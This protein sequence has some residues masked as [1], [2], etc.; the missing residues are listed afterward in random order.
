MIR[1]LITSNGN[2]ISDNLFVLRMLNILTEIKGSKVESVWNNLMVKY[3]NDIDDN[4]LDTK[5][6]F[7][8]IKKVFDRAYAKSP[9]VNFVEGYVTSADKYKNSVP[10][11]NASRLSAGETYI[12][13]DI[14]MRSV[15]FEYVIVYFIWSKEGGIKS[16]I[17]TYGSCFKY[18]LYL[19]DNCC[20][21][22]NLDSVEGWQGILLF[23]ES[24]MDKNNFKVASDLFWGMMA[25]AICHE[26]SH[27]YLGHTSRKA[28]NSNSY[29]E[30]YVADSAGYDIFLRMLS[31]EFSDIDS[32]FSEI[33]DDYIYVAPMLLFL[34]YD[35]VYYMSYWLFDEKA[36]N[37]HPS[38]GNRIQRLL[39]QSEHDRYKFDSDDGNAVLTA[40]WDISDLFKEELFYKLKNGKLEEVIRKGASTNMVGHG[41]EDAYKINMAICDAVRTYAAENNLDT[42]TLVGLTNM[43]TQIDIGNNDEER[44]LIWSFN[45]NQYTTKTVN[46]F[47]NLKKLL[48]SAIDIGLTV[49]SPGDKTETIKLG[50]LIFTKILLASTIELSDKQA[51]CIIYCHNKNAYYE[52]IPCNEIMDAINISRKD[53]EYLKKIGC[54]VIDENNN[55]RLIENVLINS[56]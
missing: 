47:F 48:I 22:G 37:S 17:N 23:A 33:F 50:L 8:Y 4:E 1:Q 43:I 20:R 14:L 2:N 13:C 34:F 44:S 27:I 29:D 35:D 36:G 26:L 12:Y 31:G 18:A 5:D 32:P 56:K 49:S 54:I 11:R 6:L 9:N 16:S 30:E 46:V 51:E 3:N 53:I 45:G 24:H 7:D 42:N 39:S 10:L 28:G 38:F 40:F 21:K 41:Y 15:L 25:F 52:V 55:T 19:F